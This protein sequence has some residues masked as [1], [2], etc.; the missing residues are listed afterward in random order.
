[1][2]VIKIIF[3]FLKKDAYRLFLCLAYDCRIIMAS[4]YV[5]ETAYIRYHFPKLGRPFPCHGPGAD[6]SGADPAS[7]PAQ[8]VLRYIIFFLHLREQVIL[9]EIRILIT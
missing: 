8:G 5:S 1:M 4:P 3:S 6:P 7:G 9:K 2:E